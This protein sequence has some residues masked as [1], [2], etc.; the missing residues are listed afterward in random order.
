MGADNLAGFHRWRNWREIAQR[1]P[2]AVLDRAPYGLR[3]LHGRFATRFAS[4]RLSTTN[5]ALLPDA[6]AP[7]W[8]YLTMPRHPLSASFL[9]KML[10]ANA[11][12]R[13]TAAS[14]LKE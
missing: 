6:P 13:H 7:R 8:A 1:V 9:R 4:A 5:A 14:N 10:G 3:A 12:L 2:I 11:F